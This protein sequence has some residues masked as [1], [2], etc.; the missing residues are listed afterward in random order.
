[1]TLKMLASVFIDK[2]DLSN[3]HKRE[4]YWMRF[5]KTLARFGSKTEEI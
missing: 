4:Y 3:P 5:L 2:T 1:M